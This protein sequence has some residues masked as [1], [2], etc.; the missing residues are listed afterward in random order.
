MSRPAP[1]HASL[2]SPLALLPEERCRRAGAQKLRGKNLKHK[3]K[4]REYGIKH[5][6]S[7]KWAYHGRDHRFR[8]AG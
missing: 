5:G 3:L 8:P 7:Y 1:D 6:Y 2:P 4:N